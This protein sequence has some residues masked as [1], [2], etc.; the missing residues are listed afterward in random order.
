MS[1]PLCPYFNKCGGCTAQHIDY[2][3]QLE[4][5]KKLIQRITKVTDVKVFSDKE[6]GYRNRMDFIFF[7]A[8]LGLRQQGTKFQIVDIANCAISEPL[9]NTLLTE[10]RQ[11]FKHIDAFDTRKK[12]G[13]FRYTIIRTTSTGDSGISFLL[14]DDSQQL[15]QAIEQIKVFAKHSTAKNILVAVLPANI[16]NNLSEETLLIKGNDYLTETLCGKTFHF[17]LQGFFQN[18][19]IVAQH[20]QQYVH[21]LFQSYPTQQ[22]HLLDL[23]AGVGTF[24]II[25]A[26]VFKSVSIVES[27]PAAIE[28]ATTNLQLNNI[29]NAKIHVLDAKHLSRL[30]FPSHLYIIADPPRIGMDQKTIHTLN[31]LKPE[32]ILYISC[33]PE[34]L[35]KD[36]PKFSNYQIKSAALF[37]LFPQTPHAEV[38]VELIRKS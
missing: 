22:A 30:S 3:L 27:Y 14:N 7:P 9:I 38:I 16:E 17:P 31:T 37:D 6:Y 23:Y 26:N 19:T 18:N 36:L 35:E 4:N 29:T 33:N 8:G 28:L 25:N 15:E 10:V 24:G 12:K 21:T 2:K 34:Q 1:T 5:K 13:T 20:M 32:V 11:F